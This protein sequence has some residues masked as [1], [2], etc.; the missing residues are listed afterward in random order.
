MKTKSS[1]CGEQKGAFT[2]IELL[3]VIAIIAILAAMLLPALARSK[4]QA[5]QTSCVNNFRQIGIGMAMYVG[6]NKAY[7]GDY[8]T[9]STSYIW[10]IRIL[11]NL[12]NARTV[13]FCPAAPPQSAWDTNVNTTLGFTVGSGTPIPGYSPGQKDP[14][15]VSNAARFSVGYNDWGLNLGNVTQ[16][17]LGGDVDG[18]AYKG[19]VK[20][21]AVVA[22]SQMIMIADTR[23]I[24]GGT[25]EAN[26][27]PTDMPDSGQA[28]DGGQEPSNRHN[29]TTDVACCDGHVER[30]LRND[31]YPGR[32][33][34]V[35]LI[36]PTPDN[37]WRSR[38]NNDNKPHNEVTWPT[39]ASTASVKATSMYNLDP[40][41]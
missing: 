31:K 40:S 21:T 30:P 33:N 39:V 8:T 9:D 14:W 17:G 37:P 34:P 5:K 3:V 26:L 28:G 18:G 13:F 23:A 2:L 15:L 22:P 24:Q 20:D 35:N 11:P 4:M 7:P 19:V 1:T 29:Y 41:F 27:D 12:G 38:W 10:M 6:D 25:W 16:L 36:D 32:P